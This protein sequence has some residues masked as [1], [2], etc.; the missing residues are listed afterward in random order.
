TIGLTHGIFRVEASGFHGREP[1]EF[2]WDLD[3]GKI[4][5]WSARL[6]IQ[7]GADWSGQVSYARLTSP[8]AVFPT[9]DQARLTASLM[10]NRRLRHGNWASSVV[11]GRTRSFPDDS[12]FNSYLLEST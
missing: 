11:W 6:T 9:E 7:P 10:Y 1:D 4:D 3:S 5:S 12:I 8:E 2:R